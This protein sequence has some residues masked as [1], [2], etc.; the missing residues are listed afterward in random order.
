MWYITIFNIAKWI[1]A[2]LPIET[3]L[4][5][6]F[7]IMIQKISNKDQ[8]EKANMTLLHC[9]ESIKLLSEIVS[10]AI[11]NEDEVDLLSTEVNKLKVLLLETWSKKK[12]SK[13]IE[14]KI[15]VLE[16]DKG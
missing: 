6:A 2:A 11:V 4:A 13:D 14:E 7:T 3:I 12:Y 1:F 9:T 5:K 10:D 16:S 15:K 8:L